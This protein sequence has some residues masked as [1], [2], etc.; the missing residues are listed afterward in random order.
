M[1]RPTAFEVRQESDGSEIR[2]TLVGELDL[3]TGPSMS[4]RLEK[5]LAN[6]ATEVIVD[7][8]EL[9]FMDSTRL[10]LLIELNN[11]SERE[12]WQLRLVGPKHEAA[13]LVLRATGTD[14]SLPFVD[15]LH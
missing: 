1:R 3:R 6:G 10:R 11:R 9:A 5:I 14:T 7:L 4:E 2:L 13:A 8:S 12:R 15:S